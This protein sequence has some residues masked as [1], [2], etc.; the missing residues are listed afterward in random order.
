M[1]DYTILNL[2][3]FFIYYEFFFARSLSLF[4]SFSLQLLLFYFHLK[5]MR[6]QMFKKEIDTYGWYATTTFKFK[7]TNMIFVLFSRFT[8]LR[9]QKL[10]YMN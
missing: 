8:F 6:L 4:F 7:I 10:Y 9:I 1:D 3:V 5:F 2:P